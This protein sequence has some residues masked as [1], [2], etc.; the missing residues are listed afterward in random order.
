MSTFMHKLAEGL[1]TREQYLE[2][3]SEHPVFE[4][5]TGQDIKSEYNDL[6][7]D[8]KAF[9]DRVAALEKEG[10][11]FDEHFERDINKE[12]EHL[13]VKI[14]TWSKKIEGK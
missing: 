1:R 6:V 13:S 9:S 5:D 4:T 11:D 12:L 8:L 3:H 2:D 14:D 10:V 7:A